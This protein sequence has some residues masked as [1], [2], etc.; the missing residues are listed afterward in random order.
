MAVVIV[1]VENKF[2]DGMIAEN[3]RWKTGIFMIL[4]FLLFVK[5]TGRRTEQKS[6][7][8]FKL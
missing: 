4:K 6:S 1:A 8:V 7:E 5:M 2:S 3:N